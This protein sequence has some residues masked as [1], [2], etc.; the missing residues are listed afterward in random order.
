MLSASAAMAEV[1]KV[2]VKKAKV[3]APVAGEEKQ[4]LKLKKEALRKGVKALNEV[5]KKK[6]STENALFES[7]GE[8]MVLLFTLG[9]IPD[10]KRVRPVMIEL[11]HPLYDE[12][13]EVCF[14]SKD[15]QKKYKEMLLKEFPLPGLVKV[16]GIDK[17]RKNY[18]TL[19]AKKALRDSFDFFVCDHA[20]YEMM[21]PILG[22]TFFHAYTKAP[23]PVRMNADPRTHIKKAM[24]GTPFRVPKGPCVSVRIGRVG[25]PEE[26][27][28]ENAAAVVASVVRNLHGNPIKT[29]SVQATD[30]LA[31]PVWR[32]DAAPGGPFDFKKFHSDASSSAASD[33]GASGVSE[34]EA[35][36]SEL[37][38]DVGETIST[39]DTVS[40]P[41]TTAG[42]TTH[43]ELDSEA[44]DVDVESGA[45]DLPL[46]KGL[47]KRGK[48]RRGELEPALEAKAEKAAAQAVEAAPEKSMGPPAK[49]AKTKGGKA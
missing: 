15:P 14:F 28:V 43:S 23:I 48:K 37:P 17:L 2:E 6:S 24:S 39:R 16:I 44:G 1:K 22:K 21:P 41:E 34:T 36:D 46:L 3:E 13:S 29:I 7:A 18:K 8:T 47:K 25:M 45:S 26:H 12:K 30:S 5:V 10:K 35:L 19:E 49:K 27:L 42:E 11:P 31:L 40:E 4:K 20:I 38:S 32:R 9:Q 33:T